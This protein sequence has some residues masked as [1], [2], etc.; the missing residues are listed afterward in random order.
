MAQ[1]AKYNFNLVTQFQL[2]RMPYLNNQKNAT[3]N[4]NKGNVISKK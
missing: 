4:N 3:T 1:T 2:H